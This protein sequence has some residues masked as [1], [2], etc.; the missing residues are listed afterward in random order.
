MFRQPGEEGFDAVQAFGLGLETIEEGFLHR[1][2]PPGQVAGRRMAGGRVRGG[3]RRRLGIGGA[4]QPAHCLAELS[5]CPFRRWDFP[6][7]RTEKSGLSHV[8]FLGEST[9]G[10][11]EAL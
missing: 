8:H 3:G 4:F 7:S 6:S 10:N 11:P 2:D 9:Q 5:P 1:A